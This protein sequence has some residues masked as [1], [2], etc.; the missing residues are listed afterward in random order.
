MNK[1]LL[2][3]SLFLLL[4]Y[5]AC[6][7]KTGGLTLEQRMALLE[8]RLE[9]AEKRAE[10]A[11]RMLKSFD[12]EQHSEIRQIS[13]EQNKK[14]ANSYAV[15]E[16]T[17]E[18]TSS[19]GFLL[20][21]YNDLKFYGDVEFNIDAASKPGQLVMISSG[22]NSES[23]N[24]RWDLNGRILLGFDGTR[25]LDN[26]YFAGFSAQ[27]LADMHGSVNIDDALFFF[28]KDD[29]WKVKVGRFEAYDMFPL[30]QDTFIEYS[31]NT[32][33]DI[34]ADGR[35]Y[36][37]M[38]KEG[39]GRSDAGGNFLISKQLDNWYFE[40]NTLLEDG[41]SLY[42]NGNY[43]GRYMEQ[44]KNVAYLRPVIAWSP[45]E[46][47]TVSAAM[48][49]NVV[50]NAYGYTDNKGNFVDQSN[51][52]GYGISMTWNGLK[53]DPE[54][55]IVVTLNTAYLDA[56][57]E[58]DFTASINALWKRFELGYIYA[59]NKI[60]EFSGVVCNNGCWIDGEGI[61]NIHTIHASYQFANVMDMENFNIYLGA[62]YSILD[63]NCRYS[64]CDI[65]DDRYGARL[66]FKYFF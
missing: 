43:H 41:T 58:K 33:N 32:A 5:N 21:G 13:S 19:P 59:H 36:I 61:Y 31:G 10:K 42:N 57:N 25:K 20:S 15:V 23:V 65:T 30:N 9:A 1:L 17:K 27:P 48:E 63:S 56:S 6:T 49:A 37:Y 39:R 40:L 47:F 52:S 45:T 46:E 16:S 7:A 44:Q 3:L 4:E 60:D 38:M 64:N 62:Y 34:Y 55:G 12:I 28:G 50:K 51:R 8:E 11:E 29:E 53:T 2:G 22:A 14:D 35:G 66:R 18:K 54:N 24:E 26:G